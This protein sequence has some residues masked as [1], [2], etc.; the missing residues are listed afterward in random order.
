MSLLPLGGPLSIVVLTQLFA[1]ALD[2]GKQTLYSRQGI[3]SKVIKQLF[4]SC[5]YTTPCVMWMC[6]FVRLKTNIG[7][8]KLT[9]EFRN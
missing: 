3:F 1:I 7:Q 9:G 8:E 2:P 4:L 5:F 6:D